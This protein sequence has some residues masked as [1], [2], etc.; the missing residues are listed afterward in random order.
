MPHVRINPKTSPYVK[1]AGHM[2]ALSFQVHVTQTQH[3]NHCPIK[4]RHVSNT[5][6][7]PRC[8]ISL[9]K[10]ITTRYTGSTWSL[11]TTWR[12]INHKP[13]QRVQL[14]LF[15]SSRSDC[16]LRFP[17]SFTAS[18][19]L[20]LSLSV[21]TSS[22]THQRI[23]DR[24]DERASVVERRGRWRSSWRLSRVLTSRS[25]WNPKTRYQYFSY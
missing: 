21:L 12:Y 24:T 11:P 19:P 16:Q 2:N 7:C 1:F 6:F 18:F 5:L 15:I 10:K 23:G 3:T 4:S 14:L 13:K 22:E 25:K 8:A 9:D 17:L 20:S